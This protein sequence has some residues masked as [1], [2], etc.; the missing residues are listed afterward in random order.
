MCRHRSGSLD[1]L[2]WEDEHRNGCETWEAHV[3]TV[4]V[5]TIVVGAVKGEASV[6]DATWR[7]ATGPSSYG[8][9][10]AK[11]SEKSAM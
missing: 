7:R 1:H 2:H 9:A 11:L 5:L 4:L 8:S 10:P 6:G 3:W